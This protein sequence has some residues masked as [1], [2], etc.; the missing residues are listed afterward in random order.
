MANMSHELRP[1]ER[2]AGMA[3]ILL[4]EEIAPVR[5]FGEIIHNSGKCSALYYQRYPDSPAWRGKLETG[6]SAF[7]L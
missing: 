1:H 5:E 2:S 7:C 6:V 4:D 3:G